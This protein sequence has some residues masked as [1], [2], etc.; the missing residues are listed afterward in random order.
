MLKVDWAQGKEVKEEYKEYWS[1]E[2]GC[3]F[4]PCEKA[5]MHLKELKLSGFVDLDS[6]PPD[7]KGILAHELFVHNL[8]LSVIGE[9]TEEVAEASMEPAK[10]EAMPSIMPGMIPPQQMPMMVRPGFMPGPYG[11]KIKDTVYLI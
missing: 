10:L 3:N 6:V 5:P 9:L 2:D 7:R 11:G 4:I 1:K 8:E